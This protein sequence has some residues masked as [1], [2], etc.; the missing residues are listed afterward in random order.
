[1]EKFKLDNFKT[2]YHRNMPIVKNLSLHDSEELTTKL[3]NNLGYPKP[4]KWTEACFVISS[5]YTNTSE[6]V[7]YNK[8][9]SRN[10][11]VAFDK[12]LGATNTYKYRL[13]GK[14]YDRIGATFKHNLQKTISVKTLRSKWQRQ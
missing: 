14:G 3:F 5:D 4:R 12:L 7:M 11:L 2:L 6:G 1:M 10:Q 8:V 13:K 9:Q